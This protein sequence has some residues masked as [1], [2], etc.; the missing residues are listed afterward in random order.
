M[1]STFAISKTTFRSKSLVTLAAIL[2]AVAL[3]QVFHAVGAISGL[4]G[5]IGAAF[6]P[7]HIPVFIAAFLAGPVVGVLAGLI[8]P[9]LSHGISGMPTVALLPFMTIELMGFGLMAGLLHK[10]KLP[11]IL[12][13][14]I[15][16]LAGRALRSVA[17]LTAVFALGSQAVALDSIWNTIII[18]L[19]GIMLQWALIPLFIYRLK[20]QKK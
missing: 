5:N 10:N 6:L 3:P 15:A 17:V 18:G 13:L 9:L 7:M 8:S 1:K 2:C 12:N 14:I 20:G 11:V 4:G 19:P 16:Q